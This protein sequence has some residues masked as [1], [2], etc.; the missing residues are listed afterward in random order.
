M[1]IAAVGL[2][3]IPM[4]ASA[5][6]PETVPPS[7]DATTNPGNDRPTR[8]EARAIGRDHCGDYKRNFG[9]N[10]NQFG[11]CVSAVAKTLRTDRTPRQACRAEGLRRKPQRGER[12]SDFSACV[13]AARGAN[14]RG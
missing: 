9:D 5:A 8:E 1:L 14:G 7:Y 3:A 12:R 10:R 11:K 2:L 6:Q 4:S 13:A